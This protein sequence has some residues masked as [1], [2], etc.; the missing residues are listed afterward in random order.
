MYE[1]RALLYIDIVHKGIFMIC[2]R[3]NASFVGIYLTHSIAHYTYGYNI[4][5]ASK[6]DFSFYT[7]SLKSS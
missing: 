1:R 5:Y 4:K 2:Q 6:W 3:K 7:K